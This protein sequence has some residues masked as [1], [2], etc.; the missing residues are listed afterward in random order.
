[1]DDYQENWPEHQQENEKLW[2]CDEKESTC[3][4][5]SKVSDI[6][7]EKTNEN[8]FEFELLVLVL[9]LMPFSAVLSWICGVLLI[10]R[11]KF[12]L[13]KLRLAD[14]NYI[15]F[16]DP[17]LIK[18]SQTSIKDVFQYSNRPIEDTINQILEDGIDCLKNIPAIEVCIINEIYYSSDNRRLY[19][20]KEA[21]KRGLKVEKI[22]ILIKIVTDTN[23]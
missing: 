22:S 4:N 20:I 2:N 10:Y 3:S 14:S 23:I 18:Y 19:C 1:N 7:V 11:A 8:Y 16:L 6:V 21:I 5:L 15:T 9:I 17:L 13:A 12:L